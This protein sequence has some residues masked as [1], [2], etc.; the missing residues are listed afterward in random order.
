MRA[1][2][3]FSFL[4]LLVTLVASPTGVGALFWGD[5][6]SGG[7]YGYNWGQEQPLDQKQ[8]VYSYCALEAG[9]DCGLYCEECGR[10]GAGTASC[11]PYTYCQY[12]QGCGAGGDTAGC[13]CDCG[14][15]EFPN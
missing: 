4:L 12:G 2:R 15:Q 8:S 5:C 6:Y 9:S 13:E 7:E 11:E 14:C 10:A 1:V 3:N